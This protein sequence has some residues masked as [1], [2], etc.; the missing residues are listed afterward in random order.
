MRLDGRLVKNPPARHSC[1]H[2]DVIV[3]APNTN[4]QGRSARSSRV[5]RHRSITDRTSSPSLYRASGHRGRRTIGLSLCELSPLVKNSGPGADLTEDS[6]DRVPGAPGGASR[7]GSASSGLYVTAWVGTGGASPG[8]TSRLFL[9]RWRGPGGRRVRLDRRRP[10]DQERVDDRL[11]YG[12]VAALPQLRTWPARRESG[13]PRPA[14][15]RC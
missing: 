14:R 15:L 3:L 1:G 4:W 11:P 7:P 13:T 12:Q 10:Q 9:P 8:S 6:P 2:A 5:V